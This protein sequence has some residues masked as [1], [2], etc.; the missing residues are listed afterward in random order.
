MS[1]N[2][3]RDFGPF[4][5]RTWLNC[6]HQGPLPRVAFDMLKRE[7]IDISL[8][9]GNLRVSPHLYNTVDEIEHLLSILHSV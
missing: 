8:R 2:F 7:G 9:E 6:A 4:E 5:G 1:H 3:S